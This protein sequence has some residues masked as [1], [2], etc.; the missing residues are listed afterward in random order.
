SRAVGEGIFR[1]TETLVGGAAAELL[2]A[3]PAPYREQLAGLPEIITA[4]E[5][6]AA[7][8]RAQVEA[9]ED[10][11]VR[12]GSAHP[13]LIARRTTAKEQL[14]SAVAALEE[15]RLDLIRLHAGGSD[16]APLTT[17]LDA[18]KHMAEDIDQLADAQSQ[19]NRMLER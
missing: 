3:L 19:V 8:A 1:A 9:L 7:E 2:A 6:W 15:I 18:A 5:A 11:A 16:L 17:L 13:A 10:V 12:G 4:L 14:A